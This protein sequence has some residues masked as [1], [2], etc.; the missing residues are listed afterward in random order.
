MEELN[1]N[2]DSFSPNVTLRPIYQEIIL[3]NLAYVGG[4]NEIS[5]W[6]Q[7]YSLF[8]YHGVFFPQLIVRPSGLFVGGGI[9]KKMKKYDLD[10]GELFRDRDDV[11][12]EYLS[13]KAQTTS[14]EKDIHKLEEA[15]EEL[16]ETCKNF[17]SD[18]KWPVVNQAKQHI[19][20][21]KKLEK[22][23][24]KLLKQKNQKD[25]NSIQKIYDSLYPE[26]KLQERIES[27]IP[28]YLFLGDELAD[29]LISGLNPYDKSL[30][31][32]YL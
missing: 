16:L 3:P 13:E 29:L 20:D 5:Y 14:L 1:E 25:I 15:Y 21:L 27:F 30:S 28:Y 2:P 11:I 26:G 9:A 18:L 10:S 31:L 32:F 19:K 6:F 17:E 12:Q 22:D 4:T 8:K 7:L 24:R 23:T